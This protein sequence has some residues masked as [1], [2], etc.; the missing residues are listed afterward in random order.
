MRW[1]ISLRYL[2]SHLRQTIVCIAGVTISVLMF[3][4][5]TAM[6]LGFTD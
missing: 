4:T 3:I 1:F 5:M 6:M 2:L